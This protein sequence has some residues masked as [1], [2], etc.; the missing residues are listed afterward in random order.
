[1][2][3]WDGVARACLALPE[4]AEGTSRGWRQWLVR[5]KSFAWER[6]LGKKDRA[7]LGDRA[8]DATPLAVYVPDEGA[9]AALLAD[10]PGTFFTTT[11]F[12][13]YPI[14]LCELDRLDD[15]ALTELVGESWACRA[16]D[17]LVAEHRFDAG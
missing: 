5:K 11:H 16:P 13:G 2:A 12:D 15:A 7:E 14:V 6:P 3:D 1:V 9:K 8:P 17:R 10:D 4:T